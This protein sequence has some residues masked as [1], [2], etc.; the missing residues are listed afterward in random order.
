MSRND[1]EHYQEIMRMLTRLKR[2][3]CYE[4]RDNVEIRQTRFYKTSRCP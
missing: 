1:V 2:K 3:N 4:L